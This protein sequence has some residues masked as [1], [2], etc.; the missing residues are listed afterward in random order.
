[1]TLKTGLAPHFR[2]SESLRGMMFGVL[3]PLLMLLI[4][5]FLRQGLRPVVMVLITAGVCFLTEVVFSL[6]ARKE[7]NSTELSSVVTG[8]IIALLMPVNAPIWLPCAAGVFAIAVA[9]MPFGGTGHTPFNPAAAG[10]AFVTLSWPKLVFGYRNILETLPLPLLED[11]TV[12]VVRS[13]AATLKMGAIPTGNPIDM[14]FGQVAGPIGATSIAVIAACLLFLLFRRSARWEIPAA[15]LAS[16]ALFAAI[17]PRI[18]GTRLESAVYELLAGSLV[19]AAVFMATEPTTAPKTGLG[20]TLY[21][22]LGGLAVMLF[23]HFGIFEEGVVFAIL[24]INTLEPAL[25]RLTLKLI[26]SGGERRAK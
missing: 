20:R 18:P 1:M 2:R 5:P 7:I 15:F 17:F 22:T 3:L 23:R 14:L 16:A 21:G 19:F 13:P 9:K 24:L 25:D 26:T 4:L 10:V 12:D 11:V 8:T 6:F